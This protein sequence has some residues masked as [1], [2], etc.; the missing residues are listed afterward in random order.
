MNLR[1]RALVATTTVVVATSAGCQS[2]ESSGAIDEQDGLIASMVEDAEAANA[3]PEQIAILAEAAEIGEVSFQVYS[4]AV[5][6]ALRCIREAGGRV[7]DNG[8]TESAG[9]RKRSYFVGVEAEE[10]DPAEPLPGMSVHRCIAEHSFWVEMA[11]Q[12]QPSSVEA[13]EAAWEQHRDAIVACLRDQGIDVAGDERMSELRRT[14]VE[15]YN[16]HGEAD[17]DCTAAVFAEED[18]G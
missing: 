4:D 8:T 10:A 11:Y 12:N 6:R 15:A 1:M 9:V 18:A 7:E 17:E 5:D 14:A 3:S 16:I 13:R 2:D